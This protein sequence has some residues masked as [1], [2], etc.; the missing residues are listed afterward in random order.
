MAISLGGKLAACSRSRLSSPRRVT[1]RLMA[2]RHGDVVDAHLHVWASAEEARDTPYALGK[3]PPA[4]VEACTS[5]LVHVMDASQVD[6]AVIVQPINHLFDHR[7]VAAAMRDYPDRF[8]GMALLNPAMAT[9]EAVAEV[10]RLVRGG[11]RGVR[12]NPYVRRS[13]SSSARRRRRRAA[14]GIRT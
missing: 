9:N 3:E 7:Y 11:F 8:A 1:Q 12:F 6:K 13:C 4:D 14:S 5:H 10:R 2:S